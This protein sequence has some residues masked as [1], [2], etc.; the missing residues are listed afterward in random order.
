[1]YIC[2]HQRL[3]FFAGLAVTTRRS[4]LTTQFQFVASGDDFFG[5]AA[6]RRR[7]HN[8]V[9]AGIQIRR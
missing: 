9:G 3:S 8:D 2:H 4:L 1:M 7:R 6:R 5:P